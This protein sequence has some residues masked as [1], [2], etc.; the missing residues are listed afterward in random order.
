MGTKGTCVLCDEPCLIRVYIMAWLRLCILY[1]CVLG[2]G[3][4][5]TCVRLCLE[6]AEIKN[7]DVS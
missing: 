2:D 7:N 6:R 4:R 3:D 5:Q 1:E